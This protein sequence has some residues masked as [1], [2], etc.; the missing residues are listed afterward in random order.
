MERIF[1][2]DDEDGIRALL[3]RV[4]DAPGRVVRT[5]PCAADALES[6]REE[7]P[8][9]VVTDLNMPEVTGNEFIGHIRGEF[10]DKVGIIVIT[11]YPAMVC[12]LDSVANGVGAFLRKPFTDLDLLRST[13]AQV[14]AG[15]R[16]RLVPSGEDEIAIS[17]ALNSLRHQRA[18][19]TRAVAVLDQIADGIVVTDRDDRVEMI[20]PAA[21]GIL[22]RSE[23][24]CLMNP[25]LS[26]VDDEA[27][28]D[29][30]IQ[31]E[32]V[33]GRWLQTRTAQEKV[34]RITTTPLVNDDGQSVGHLRVLRDSTAEHRLEEIK[35]H[36]L[37]VVAHELRTPLTVLHNLGSVL[38]RTAMSD[39]QVLVVGGMVEQCQRLEHQIDKLILLARFHQEECTGDPERIDAREIAEQSVTSFAARAKDKGVSLL[40]E[41]PPEPVPILCNRDDLRCALHELVDNALKFTARDGSV[42]VKILQ[43]S[44]GTVFRVSDTGIGIDPSHH[45]SIFDEFHQLEPPHT[46]TYSGAGLGLALSRRI[47]EAW[48]GR[49]RMKSGVGVG[50]TFDIVLCSASSSPREEE[51]AVA[52]SRGART[53]GHGA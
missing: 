31:G 53:D 13:V 9:V 28:R 12:N 49:L 33:A 50:S 6:M 14:I 16:R 41:C 37:T 26:L 39:R 43:D 44:E 17:S 40:C 22:M 42:S 7:P 30:L 11:A 51:K 4:L 8:D 21:A 32:N 36:Y 52:S 48:G 35:S 5:Y 45:R 18:D 38:I 10:G 34:Y 19:L 24:S 1:V 15:R 25:L 47:V 46:R 3:K 2:V 27:L 23:L 20:N 29:A